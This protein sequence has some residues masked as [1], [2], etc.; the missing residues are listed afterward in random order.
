MRFGLLGPA[1]PFRGGIAQFL[2]HLADHL[3]L[4]NQV[5]IFTFRHQYPSLFFPGANQTGESNECPF[6]LYRVLTP[7]NPIS[8]KQTAQYIYQRKIN[9]LIIQFWIPYFC[10][11]YI[12]IC[13]FLKK[14][15]RIKITL[16]CHNLIFHEKWLFSNLLVY[17]MLKH[18]DQIVVLS[19]HVYREF[20]TNYKTMVPKLVKMFHPYYEVECIHDKYKACQKIGIKPAPTI[21]FFGFIKKYK[22]LDVLLKAFELVCQENPQIQLLIAGEVYGS[23]RKYQRLIA[24]SSYQNQIYFHHEY[25]SLESIPLYFQSCDVVVVP[26]KTASQSG[27]IQL[28]YSFQKPVIASNIDGLNEAVIEEKTGFLFQNKDHFDLAKRIRQFFYSYQKHNYPD[29]ISNF[30]KD[31]TWKIFVSSNIWKE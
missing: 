18:V 5:E 24:R 31:Y 4:L 7:Y 10:P 21:L 22:G 8:W 27:V 11:A 30:N 20:L 25:I 3:G 19:D 6:P 2:H 1:S 12:T 17:L 29:Q 16:I 14:H 15:C 23:I 26:Y 9:H 28:A 13:K